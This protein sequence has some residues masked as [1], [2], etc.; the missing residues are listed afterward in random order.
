MQVLFD[1]FL[2]LARFSLPVITVLFVFCCAKKLLKK[3]PTI[4]IASIRVEGMRELF[5][6]N[7]C[8]CILGRSRIC[9]IRLNL[10]TVSRRHAVLTFSKDYGF[11]I[12]TV[13]GSKIWVNGIKVNEYA[14][15]QS[16][17]K[18]DI[19]GAILT[20]NPPQ[21]S[22]LSS[23]SVNKRRTGVFFELFLLSIIQLII[24]G[25]L[26]IHYK[27]DF[28]VDILFVFGILFIIE[29]IYILLSKNKDTVFIDMLGFL[30]TSFGF[31]VAASAT[32]SSLIKQLVAFVLGFAI[33]V[34]AGFVM[35]NLEFTAK[36]RYL[37]TVFT[38]LLFAI[39]LIFGKNINGAKNWIAIGSF[40][41]Q[42]SEILKFAFVF[43]GASTLDRL[44]AKRNLF[45][46]LI[47]SGFCIGSLA[48]M[49]DFG[50]ASI[51]FIT[52]LII[53]FMRSGD[54]KIL[55]IVTGGAGVAAILVAN[56]VPYVKR[57]FATFR[58][59]W[60][61]ASDK[62]Y[63]Q[64]R[65][66]IAIASGGLFGVGIGNGNLDKVAASDTD[67][68]FGILAEEMGLICAVCALIC[69][70]I[71]AL[72]SWRKIPKTNSAFYAISAAAAS[73]LF[74]FQISLNVFGSTDLLPLTGVT[75]PFVSNG[76]SSMIASWAL[77]SFIK[78]VGVNTT[79]PSYE[80]LGGTYN[81]YDND[82]YYIEDN[83]LNA[84]FGFDESIDIEQDA[85]DMSYNINDYED[86]SSYSK[87]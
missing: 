1:L 47:F 16:G 62:G 15:L 69:F 34:L 52:I 28:C 43:V 41:F 68:V 6:V 8:E 49:R 74:I 9:D 82:D 24:T 51:Y 77:L 46:F 80:E 19:G 73:C 54:L 84:E 7:G 48:L 79:R 83:E 44:L 17:D 25:E 59:A 71:F 55:S 23:L 87:E 37:L 14:Y 31:A 26:L 39:N 85:D 72:Y 4:P 33:Y 42:P 64:T 22:D 53:M 75:M 3:S 11:K 21:Y 12:N 56:F 50:T 38:V 45:L 63:Q 78:A 57:R 81:E 58:H 76:G 67:L 36:M 32:P 61:F 60:E 40:T 86:I 10:A 13:N 20:I 30:L 27:S 66:M 29:W 70:V 2:L 18:I 35:K 5:D 65:T